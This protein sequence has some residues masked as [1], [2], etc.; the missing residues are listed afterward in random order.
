MAQKW[1]HILAEFAG[2][3]SSYVDKMRVRHKTSDVLYRR[4]LSSMGYDVLDEKSCHRVYEDE[5]YSLYL[6]GLGYCYSV[7]V[8]ECVRVKFWIPESMYRCG[9]NVKF[10]LI[11]ES[12]EKLVFGDIPIVRK[13]KLSVGEC[14]YANREK[15]LEYDFRLWNTVGKFVL[16]PDYYVIRARYDDVVFESLLVVA[17]ARAYLP[18]KIE[19]GKKIL[20]LGLQLYGLKSNRNFGIGDFGDLGKILPMVAKCGCDLLGINPLGPMYAKGNKDVS[21]YICKLPLYRFKGCCRV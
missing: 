10:E 1:L 11:R 5:L 6:S 2:I 18:P 9:A 14:C 13:L 16:E 7:F 4:F 12:D 17:P 19:D 15:F 8:G 3:T 21:P 20:G